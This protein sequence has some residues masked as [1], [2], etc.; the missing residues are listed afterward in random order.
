MNNMTLTPQA[1]DW[2]SVMLLVAET[3]AAGALVLM[4]LFGEDFLHRFLSNQNL[5]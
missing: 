4:L 3:V 1:I 5:K 2:V